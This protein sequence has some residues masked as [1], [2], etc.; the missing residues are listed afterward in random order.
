M[1]KIWLIIAFS[2]LIVGLQAQ[3][4]STSVYFAPATVAKKVYTDNF[5]SYTNLAYLHDQE[6]W[7]QEK[8]TIQIQNSTGSAGTISN[9]G[10]VSGRH[11]A[12]YYDDT[13]NANQYA[14]ISVATNVAEYIGICVR[15]SGAGTGNYYAYIASTNTR[16]L[17]KVVNNTATALSTQSVASTTGTIEL[18]VVGNELQMYWDGAL[19]TGMSNTDDTGK[20]TD[21]TF[22]TGKVGVAG[23]GAVTTRRGDTWEGGEL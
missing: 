22:S 5:D 21:A 10:G 1:K 18:R 14:K 3:V 17:Y 4:V 13:F 11:Q 7:G 23:R 12:C 19:D 20:L 15:A 16:T 6:N 2:W 9:Q 8:D